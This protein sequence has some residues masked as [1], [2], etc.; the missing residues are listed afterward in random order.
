MVTEE[1]FRQW[2]LLVTVNVLHDNGE[3]W[4][5]IFSCITWLVNRETIIFLQIETKAKT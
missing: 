5:T 2:D 4:R 3:V 1:N